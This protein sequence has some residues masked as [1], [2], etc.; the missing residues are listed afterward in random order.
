MSVRMAGKA[1]GLAERVSRWRWGVCHPERSEGSSPD[2][3]LNPGKGSA[4]KSIHSAF[5]ES[6]SAGFL[7]RR[8][9]AGLLEV[10]QAGD[11][12][13][14]GESARM[15]CAVLEE[16]AFEVVG[17]ADVE[18]AAV[19]GEDVDGVGPTRHPYR[20]TSPAQL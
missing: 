6:I 2:D 5:T 1:A 3:A 17:D 20:L 9:V 11:T 19:A 12:V 13:L 14:R 16:P 15:S 8:N 4:P 7:S 10:D 18:P